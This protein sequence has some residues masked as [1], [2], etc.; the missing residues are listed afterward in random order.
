MNDDRTAHIA[1]L[2]KK[3]FRLP[4]TKIALL[5]SLLVTLLISL[6]FILILK[7]L[8]DYSILT[9]FILFSIITIAFIDTWLTSFSPISSFRRI[10]FAIFFELFPLILL[11]VCSFFLIISEVLTRSLFLG[12][13]LLLTGYVLSI[14]FFLMYV[15]FYKDFFKTIFPTI[16]LPVAI[17]SSVFV[18]QPIKFPI[19]VLSLLF[20]S[21][22]L[23]ATVLFLRYIDRVGTKMLKVNSFQILTSYLQSWI[24][25]IPNELE[26]ILEKYSEP[27]IIKT[28]QINL[29]QNGRK[30]CS[31]N[32][33]NS[34]RSFLSNWKL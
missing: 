30:L 8:I 22:F 28:Y 32:S 18:F 34:S 27:S 25:S 20:S 1:N 24:S 2:Y 17:Y 16:L 6:P 5:F 19:I 7:N 9:S 29:N 26:E 12:I 10:I 11:S 3:L 21:I 33:R 15:I 31:S 14:R 23:G 13:F 4:S